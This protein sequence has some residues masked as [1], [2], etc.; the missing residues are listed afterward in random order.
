MN[1]A[2]HQWAVRNR[3]SLSALN[4]LKGLM[5][6]HGGHTMPEGVKGVSES[7]TSAVL[8]LEA[9]RKNVRLWRNNVGVLPD[10][11]G[12]PVRYGLANESKQM[13]EVLKSSDFIGWRPVTI[14]PQHVGTMIAQT[15][16]RE[17][18]KVGWVYTGDAHEQGQLAWLMM[19]AADGCDAAFAT[20]EGTL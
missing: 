19:G 18:K 20:G 1:P 8:R 13:N 9:G 17:C 6:M 3:V 2:I 4:E 10:V 11:T 5:G 14:E 16:L 7:A 12:R 15:V